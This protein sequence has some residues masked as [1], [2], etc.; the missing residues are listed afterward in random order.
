MLSPVIKR[1]HRETIYAVIITILM[2]GNDIT[3]QDT[4]A[5]HYIITINI[6]L[7]PPPVHDGQCDR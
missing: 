3:V 5:N 7:V 2:F 6:I 4:Y 1:L